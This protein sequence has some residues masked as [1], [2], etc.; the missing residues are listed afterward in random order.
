MELDEAC[1]MCDIHTARE[2]STSASD[3]R[4]STKKNRLCP[5]D[6][7]GV[8]SDGPTGANPHGMAVRFH[9]TD[10]A[11]VRHRREFAEILPFPTIEQ[12]RDFL[13]AVAVSG[14]GAAKPTKVEAFLA[15]HPAAPRAFATIATPT[16]LRGKHNGIDAFILVNAAG[17]RQPVRFR[18][19][20]YDGTQHLGVAE[21]AAKPPIS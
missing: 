10:G 5:E 1:R 15:S 2:S 6:R 4:A 12:F 11:D 17:K 8:C 21:A 16:S 3:A 13:R 19:V 9:Q 14:P 20:P 7:L 18:A